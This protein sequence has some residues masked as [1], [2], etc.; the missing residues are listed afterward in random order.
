MLYSGF[1]SGRPDR[2]IGPILSLPKD[3]CMHIR[4]AALTLA[5]VATSM[6]TPAMAVQPRVGAELTWTNIKVAGETFNPLAA[7]LRLALALTPDWEIGVLG[8]AGIA[9]DSEV[10]VT[11]AIGEFYSGYVR[12]SASLDDNA[13]L[14][15]NAGYGAMTLDVTSVLPG[16]PGSE[17][18]SGIVYG[19]SLEERL[20]SHPHWIGSLDLERWY[21]DQG[22]TISAV[23]Y[24]FRR[25]F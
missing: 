11:A 20:A 16:F 21:D 15:L 17:T 2:I 18:Y 19:I 23:S 7:R 8:G 5:C 1:P 22:L 4:A 14:V 9:D 24:G 25:E 12:Y 3:S 13:R 10:T 6:A